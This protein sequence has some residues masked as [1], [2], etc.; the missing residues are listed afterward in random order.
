MW[1]SCDTL[2]NEINI[3][4]LQLKNKMFAKKAVISISY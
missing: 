2:K 1:F 3:V 4:L